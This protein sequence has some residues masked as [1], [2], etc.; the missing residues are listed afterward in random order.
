MEI[1]VEKKNTWQHLPKGLM[2]VIPILV[3][4][5]PRKMLK[6]KVTLFLPIE[7]SKQKVVSRK[8]PYGL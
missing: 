2:T 1:E 3:N 8:L 4:E 5:L 6:Y 7:Q